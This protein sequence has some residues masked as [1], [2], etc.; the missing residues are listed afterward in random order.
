MSSAEGMDMSSSS[1]MV[2]ADTM[3]MSAGSTIVFASTMRLSAEDTA[4]YLNPMCTSENKLI[5]VLEVIGSVKRSM[6]LIP[7]AA[8]PNYARVGLSSGLLR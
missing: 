6:Q 3:N 1:T 5:R 8:K 2:S 7:F 4:S